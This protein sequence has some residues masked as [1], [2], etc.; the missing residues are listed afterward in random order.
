MNPECYWRQE[1]PTYPMYWNTE[2]DRSHV[3]TEGG[4]KENEFKFCPFCGKTIRTVRNQP[5]LTDEDGNL[6]LF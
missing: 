6:E 5:I 3:F 2:C 4:P 1:S